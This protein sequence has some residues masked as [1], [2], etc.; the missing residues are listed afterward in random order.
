MKGREVEDERWSVAGSGDGADISL[1]GRRTWL[2]C[3]VCCPLPHPKQLIF[4]IS[5]LWLIFKHGSFP[6]KFFRGDL[7]WGWEAPVVMATHQ[8][9]AER[10]PMG[11]GHWLG[12]EGIPKKR[13]RDCVEAEEKGSWAT[14]G[15]PWNPKSL[16]RLTVYWDPRVDSVMHTC[17]HIC[18]YMHILPVHTI[19]A[20]MLHTCKNHTSY[21]PHDQHMCTITQLLKNSPTL[22][23]PTA[24]L[25][26]CCSFLSLYGVPSALIFPK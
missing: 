12:G 23:S 17:S 20:Y 11:P 26:V 8:L 13:G 22:E 3:P 21:K 9:W 7:R 10:S 2:R 25:G 6:D 24:P 1:S 14:Q 16:K 18:A 4:N 15:Y 19:H 5:I